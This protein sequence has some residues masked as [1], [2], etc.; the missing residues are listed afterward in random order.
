MDISYFTNRGADHM[1]LLVDCNIGSRHNRASCGDGWH[2]SSAGLLFNY[3]MVENPMAK[4]KYV[5]VISL[6]LKRLLLLFL[7]SGEQNSYQFLS[8]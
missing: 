8:F 6:I 5:A 1:G 4:L 2:R 3:A 7:L